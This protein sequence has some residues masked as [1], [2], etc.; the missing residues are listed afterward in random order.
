[1]RFFIQKSVSSVQHDG[2]K[3]TSFKIMK[4]TEDNVHQITGISSDNNPNLYTI[5]EN[6]SH[7]NE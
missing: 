7:K 2:K 3:K 5:I 1:M 6:K 4:G